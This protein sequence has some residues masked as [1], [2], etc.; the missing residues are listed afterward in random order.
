M[1]FQPNCDGF[2]VEYFEMLKTYLK[3]KLNL[4]KKKIKT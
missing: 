3:K 2:T 1:L 4:Y